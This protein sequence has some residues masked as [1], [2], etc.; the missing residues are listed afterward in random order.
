[1]LALSELPEVN[2]CS[3]CPVCVNLLV[4]ALMHCVMLCRAVPCRAVLCCAVLCCVI[5]VS[6]VQS[7]EKLCA[8]GLLL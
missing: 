7:E 8:H 1:M 2:I 4:S 6:K 5:S 3:S